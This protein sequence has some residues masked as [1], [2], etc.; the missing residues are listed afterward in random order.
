M[1][2]LRTIAF[3]FL[4]VW[5]VALPAHADGGD[6][7]GIRAVIAAQMAAFERDDGTAAF[8]YA[9][10]GIQAGLGTPERFMAMV[11]ESYTPVYRPSRWSFGETVVADGT[12]A[13]VVFLTGRDGARQVALYIME[14][15]A[16]GSWR[17][18]GV[19]LHALAERDI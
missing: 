4:A 5:P 15:Q 12:H 18:G 6:V 7:A 11:R 16:D 19:T 2:I 9:S 17:I 14:R 1:S 10:P 3:L 8:A 13:Q